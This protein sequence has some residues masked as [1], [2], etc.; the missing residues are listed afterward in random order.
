LAAAEKRNCLSDLA[1]PQEAMVI[2]CGEGRRGEER[3]ERE[4][5]ERDE[6]GERGERGEG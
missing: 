1:G 2:I 5:R 4:I 6:R 3:D